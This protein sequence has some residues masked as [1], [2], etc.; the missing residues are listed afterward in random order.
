[1]DLRQKVLVGLRWSAGAKF[2]G[3]LITWIITLVVVRLLTPEDYGIMALAWIFVAF[4][5]LLNEL[6]LGASLI[7]RRDIDKITLGGSSGSCC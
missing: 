4:L 2:L 5:T 7:Q 1:M 6:G 3:Q